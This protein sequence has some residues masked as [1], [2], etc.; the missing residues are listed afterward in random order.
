MLNNIGWA[1]YLFAIIIILSIYYAFVVAVY[2]RNDLQ[3]HFIKF[4]GGVRLNSSSSN[5]NLTSNNTE[6]KS[7]PP[8]KEDQNNSIPELFLSFQSLIKNGAV[9][10][11][12]KE[13]LLLSLKLK[14]QNHLAL[15]DSIH[16]ESINNFIIAQCENYCSMHLSGDEVS[17][18][19]IK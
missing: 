6:I 15:K 17:A 10:N 14:L 8:K 3:S 7:D 2:Y 19:W 11:F 18:L 12:P 4:K 16:Q 1:S 5:P 9:R 13:E